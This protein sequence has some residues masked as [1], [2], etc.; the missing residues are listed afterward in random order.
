M[1]VEYRHNHRS[2]SGVLG[3]TIGLVISVGMLLAGTYGHW[4][5]YLPAAIASFA[6]FC[7]ALAFMRNTN[8]GCSVGQTHL[9]WWNTGWPKINCSIELSDILKIQLH[10]RGE[11]TQLRVMKMDR[12]IVKLN[13]S[14]I[15]T[16]REI[17]DALVMHRPDIDARIDGEY[18]W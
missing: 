6:T 9:T 1:L 2:S 10:T 11:T 7:F 4:L 16:G 8:Q 15:G 5:W 14:F 18:R 13:D 17:Y 3:G 12:T